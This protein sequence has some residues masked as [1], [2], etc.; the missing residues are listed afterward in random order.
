[1]SEASPRRKLLQHP[2]M[3]T[4]SPLTLSKS[5]TSHLEH[6]KNKLQRAESAA[7]RH[8]RAAVAAVGPVAVEP[9]HAPFDAGAE[10][11]AGKA[12]ILDDGI[13]HEARMAVADHRAR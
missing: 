11:G 9:D 13:A 2:I 8:R 4:P 6:Y 12:A 10:A 3:E 1:T 7:L 5:V